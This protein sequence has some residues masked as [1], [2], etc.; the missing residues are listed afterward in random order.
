[1]GAVVRVENKTMPTAP[2]ARKAA[3]RPKPSGELPDELAH[4]LAHLRTVIAGYGSAL[5]AFSG[6]VDSA[7]VLAVAFSVKP[8]SVVAFTAV[9]ETMAEREA[10][11][12]AA[13]AAHLGVPH[14]VARSHELSR[15][16][17]AQNPIDRC[18]H[19]K[20]ELFDLSDPHRVRLGLDH[21]VLG[22]NLD[23]LSDHRPG[24]RAA[25][26]RGVKQPLVE[27][28]LGKSEVRALAQHLGLSVWDKPQLAC[29]SS[30]FPYG[31]QLTPGR[32]RQVDRLEQALLDLGFSQVRVRFHELPAPFGN[33]GPDPQPALARIEVMPAQIPLA[34]ERRQDIVQAAL[35]AGFVYV[36]VDLQGFR[37]GSGNLPLGR[38]PVLDDP[39]PVPAP[40]ARKLVVAAL[41]RDESG[42]VLLGLRSPHQN[43]PNLWELPGG[44]I[45]PSET[46]QAALLRELREELDVEAEITGLY[47]V[48]SFAY[49]EF[50]LLMLVFAC[51]LLGVP[52]ARQVSQVRFVP[53]EQA[54]LL[55]LLPADVPLVRALQKGQD[56]S[57]NPGL[58]LG[59]NLS[60]R[61][62]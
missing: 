22:T 38:L 60:L 56:P 62:N 6:G 42:A 2:D 28:R 9:S 37:S 33:P 1:M 25:Q 55:P 54:L 23:D 19:C 52:R 14:V 39:S 30:R 11:A 51:R 43:M 26:E 40:R 18:Y 41:V 3:A 47:D 16:G 57:P 49:P 34:L 29:L 12:A 17:F 7:L 45:E 5:V 24:L 50:D 61:K 15:P 36:T 20:T 44:K 58:G 59:L 48:V 27:A 31:T 13:F 53:L 35:R 4:K 10:E 8:Q 21:I 32:L 46:P